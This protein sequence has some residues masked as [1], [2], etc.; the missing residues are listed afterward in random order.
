MFTRKDGDAIDE[1]N[2]GAICDA[3]AGLAE[4]YMPTTNGNGMV[5]EVPHGTRDHIQMLRIR[6]NDHPGTWMRTGETGELELS[7]DQALS[8]PT[9]VRF[10]QGNIVAIDVNR[11][12]PWPTALRDYLRDRLPDQYRNLQM[13]QIPDRT[14]LERLNR[15]TS[16]TS[17]QV[18]LSNATLAHIPQ[19]EHEY[20]DPLKATLNV[21][22]ASVLEVGWKRWGRDD[23]LNAEMLKALVRYFI[24]NANA[25]DE[26]SQ[27]VMKGADRGGQA[28]SF[29]LMRDFV[30]TNV[31]IARSA[32][33]RIDNADAFEKLRTAF[34]SVRN[35]IPP[36]DFIQN[37]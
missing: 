18:R 36:Q 35:R 26:K 28:E 21:G 17:L 19:G 10:F 30:M 8:E 25:L 13:V 2:S 6:W 37:E 4:P 23:H 3:V 1:I 24:E 27:I 16:V 15:I 20:I 29:S 32:S 5:C 9:H 33:R 31:E 11:S 12:G 7:E 22:E 14:A 34:N